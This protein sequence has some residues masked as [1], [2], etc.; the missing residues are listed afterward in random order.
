MPCNNWLKVALIDEFEHVLWGI[1]VNLPLIFHNWKLLTVAIIFSF[2]I[3]ID[4][5]I[6]AR[7][8]SIKRMLNLGG[9]PAFHSVPA[10]LAIASIVYLISGSVFITAVSLN[11]MGSHLIWDLATGGV[12][13]IYPWPKKFV[14][15]KKAAFLLFL[16][17]FAIAFIIT[18]T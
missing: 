14:I 9:R 1:L 3:D 13:L 15:S 17:L 7:S 16:I 12:K 8:L 5:L 6:W 11:S 2:L 10:V 4:H 18:L